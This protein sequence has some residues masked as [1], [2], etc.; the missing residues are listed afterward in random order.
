MTC[1]VR[2]SFWGALV[3]AA[4]FT[5][6]ACDSGPPSVSSSASGGEAGFNLDNCTIP[7][8]R[9]VDGG[10]GKDG[11][12][13]LTNPQLANPGD[14]SVSYLADRDRVIGLL[15]GDVP[16]A[17]PHNILW[18]HEIANFNSWEGETFAVSYC[19]LTGSSLVFDRKPVEGAEFGVS[20]LLFNNNLVMYDRRS[21]ES[22]WPQMNRQSNCG[23][24]VGTALNMLPAM[25]M[26]WGRWKELHPNTKVVSD[27]TGHDRVYSAR[28][29]PYGNYEEEDNSRLLFDMPIDDRRPPK[30]RLLG[31]PNGSGGGI[32]LPFGALAGD[33]P[34]RVVTVAVG[35]GQKTV[36]WS[37]TA[38]SAMAYETSATFSVEN[39]QIVD[40]ETGSVWSVGGRAV[41]GP[42]EGDQLTPVNEAYVAFWFAWAAFQPQTTIW[43]P[44]S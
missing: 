25:E 19:P 20:G 43:T 31:I 40:D 14:G 1:F 42:R 34:A 26:T 6:S 8:D 35:G 37:R 24:V 41:S 16:L 39:G 28:G 32:A 18:H 21:E 11:I 4:V 17:V 13:A 27:N 10:V 9:L 2:R 23:A 44:S 3:L 30:E 15:F 22:L 29:Y 36:L 38:Q 7:T 5:L 33:E 12:P